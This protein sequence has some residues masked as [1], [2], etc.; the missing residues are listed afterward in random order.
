MLGGN[1]KVEGAC[2]G[3][4]WVLTRMEGPT[5]EAYNEAAAPAPN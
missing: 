1:K 3:A 4:W 2:F 5:P